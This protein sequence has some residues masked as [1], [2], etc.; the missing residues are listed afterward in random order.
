MK[1]RE[2][3]LFVERVL[4][5]KFQVVLSAFMFFILAYLCIKAY[6]D[7][8]VWVIFFAVFNIL[9][10]VIT[11]FS[12]TFR[13]NKYLLSIISSA[14]LITI[15]IPQLIDHQRFGGLLISVIGLVALLN[16]GISLH[17]IG[18]NKLVK[19]EHPQITADK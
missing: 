3:I 8:D 19:T 10:S 17:T 12:C 18:R 6:I 4:L 7:F 9:F 11:L 13:Q 5:P 15:N 2:K 16:T 1:T 14:Q